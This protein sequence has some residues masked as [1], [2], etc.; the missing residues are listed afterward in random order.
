MPPAAPDRDRRVGEVTGPPIPDWVLAALGPVSDGAPLRAGFTNESWVV[1]TPAGRRLVL[2][3]MT[4]P[5]A[6]SALLDRA[7]AVIAGLAGAGIDSP[8]PIA[9]RSDRARHLVTSAFV[10]GASGM[11]LMGDDADGAAVGR[12][13]GTNW[14]ALGAVD[15]SGLGLDDLWAR[16]A[17]LTAAARSWLEPV[18]RFLGRDGARRVDERLAELPTLLR[19][20]RPGFVHG[21]LVPANLL[22]ADGALAALLDLEAV[23]LG[24]ALLDA[25]WFRWIVRYH[26]PVIE[27][28]VW[29]GFVASSHLDPATARVAG[30]LETL[31]IV[32]ILEILARPAVDAGARSRWFEQLRAGVGG[33]P[34]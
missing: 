1:T 2:T 17:D 16:P 25:A 24:E 5:E 32:R 11:D 30:L 26:H 31:P 13:A 23:R 27:P 7:P 6:A 4:D 29:S 19:D 12:I 3:R 10:E 8:V 33:L 9:D 15:P 22:I 28:S 20:R 18:A 21:D 34:G 14:R